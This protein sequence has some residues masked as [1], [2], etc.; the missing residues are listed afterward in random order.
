MQMQHNI[1]LTLQSHL[2]YIVEDH[3]EA[4]NM[5]VL[6]SFRVNHS[7]CTAPTGFILNDV[8]SCWIQRI[9]VNKFPCGDT[10]TE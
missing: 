5:N 3:R 2:K 6:Q 1:L 8:L 10:T 7:R 9:I 4:Q